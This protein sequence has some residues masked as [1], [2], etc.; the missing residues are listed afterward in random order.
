MVRIN[1][2][3]LSWWPRRGVLRCF[4]DSLKSRRFWPRSIPSAFMM[5]LSNAMVAHALSV[6]WEV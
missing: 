4:V 1:V 3:R 6:V 5:M 2:F